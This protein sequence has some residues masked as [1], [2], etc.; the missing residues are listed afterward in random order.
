MNTTA[1]HSLPLLLPA[2]SDER[3][4]YSQARGVKTINSL[5]GEHGYI[6]EQHIYSFATDCMADTENGKDRE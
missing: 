1:S 6:L 2:R 5:W 3:R 4:L